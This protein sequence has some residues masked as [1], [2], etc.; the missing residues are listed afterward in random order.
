MWE[1]YSQLYLL[2]NNKQEVKKTEIADILNY[3]N[4]QNLITINTFKVG[5]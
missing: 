1:L 5:A 2:T 4:L 3:D